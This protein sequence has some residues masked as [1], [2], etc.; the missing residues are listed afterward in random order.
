VAKANK[1]DS[2]QSLTAEASIAEAVG[3]AHSSYTARNPASAAQH[4]E[5]AGVMPGGNTRTVLFYEPFPL[6]IVRGQ[7]CKIRDADGHDYFDFM[8]EYTAGIAGHSNPK[9]AEAIKAAVDNGLSLSGHTRAEA[10]FA[11]I[12]SERFPAMELLRF[13]NS[14]TEATP[15][16]L[17]LARVATGRECDGLRRRVS[18]LGFR[19]QGYGEPGQCALRLG[20]CALQ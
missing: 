10:R 12:I 14:G 1:A 9:I 13:T 3:Q 7:G 19:L 17:T 11:Q 2:G 16:A 20:I 5:A 15:L 8:G 6:T 18:R 4:A